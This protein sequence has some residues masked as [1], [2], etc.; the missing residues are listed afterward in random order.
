MKLKINTF[1]V[2]LLSPYLSNY[3]QDDSVLLEKIKKM[4]VS[5]SSIQYDEENI[6]TPDVSFQS[7]Y[8][9]LSPYGEWIQISKEEVDEDLK[10]GEGQGY[11]FYSIPDENFIFIWRPGV[12]D[13]Q[14]KP[15][16][17]GRW[18]YTTHGWLWVSNYSWGWGPYHYGRWWNSKKYG[19]VWLPGYVWAPAWVIWKVSDA[20]IGWCALS[21]NARWTGEDGIVQYNYKHPDNQWVFIEKSK[22]TNDI[23]E[24]S[25]VSPKENQTIISK[26][27]TVLNLKVENSRVVNYGPDVWDVEKSSGKTIK[28][29]EINIS[30]EKAKTSVGDTEV[31]LYKENFTKG[32]PHKIDRPKKYKKSPKVKKILKK[33]RFRNLP[34]RD[35]RR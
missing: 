33:R 26:S 15:Y 30:R 21:P 6:Y 3:A 5:L 8:D 27:Q 24:L 1:L 23:N 7:F 13:K 11:A 28:Q 31:N 25:I 2:I 17:N 18:E 20:H 4:E 9:E 34:P 35:S 29:K 14:W 22:F 10:N 16:I 32:K 19:W 12:Q